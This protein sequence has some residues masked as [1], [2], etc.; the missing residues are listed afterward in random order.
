MLLFGLRQA[1]TPNSISRSFVTRNRAE[2]SAHARRGEGN[3]R[4]QSDRRSGM[5]IIKP[6]RVF[7]C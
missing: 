6:S 2:D 5:G 7:P 4:R 1:A 3:K